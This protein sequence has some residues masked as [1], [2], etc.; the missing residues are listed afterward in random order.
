MFTTVKDGHVYVHVRTLQPGDDD[1]VV[2]AFRAAFE[3]PAEDPDG[4]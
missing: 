2:A 3:T 4:P 1:D